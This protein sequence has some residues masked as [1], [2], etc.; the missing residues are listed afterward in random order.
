MAGYLSALPALQT[1]VPADE[2]R[3]SIRQKSGARQRAK[4]DWVRDGGSQIRG[5][6]PCRPFPHYRGVANGRKI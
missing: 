4:D 3:A 6:W 1:N 2:L 5:G